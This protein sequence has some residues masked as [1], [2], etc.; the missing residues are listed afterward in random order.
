MLYSTFF[1]AVVTTTRSD[2]IEFTKLIQVSME[3]PSND[4]PLLDLH[5]SLFGENNPGFNND[6][7]QE[8]FHDTIQSI[9]QNIERFQSFK[10]NSE[11]SF[12]ISNPKIL[13]SSI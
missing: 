9:E 10:T 3:G 5:V 4:G 1:V 6:I 7:N 12:V 13:I 2:N 11:V 8:E